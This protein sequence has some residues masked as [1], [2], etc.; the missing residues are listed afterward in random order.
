MDGFIPRRSAHDPVGRDWSRNKHKGHVMK[1]AV[2]FGSALLIVG[3]LVGCDRAKQMGRGFVFPVGDAAR[4]Q[5]AYIALECYTCHRVDR[6]PELPAP[7]VSPERVVVLGG[8]VA[9]V[10]TYGDLVTA[11]IHPKYEISDKLPN[12]G[13]FPE[14]PMREVNA[15]MTVTQMIDLVTFL[16]PRYHELE[17]VYHTQGL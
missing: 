13:A 7:T 10:R 6:V 1:S 15:K 2:V 3:L 11:I 17:P 8:K 5:L 4:G 16:Q 9:K 12:R 14:S